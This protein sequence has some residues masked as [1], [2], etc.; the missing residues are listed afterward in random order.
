MLLKSGKEEAQ[1]TIV[2]MLSEAFNSQTDTLERLAHLESSLAS[3]ERLNKALLAEYEKVTKERSQ[4]EDEIYSKM[5]LLLNTKKER[6]RQLES[7]FV[8]DIEAEEVNSNHN[9]NDNGFETE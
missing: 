3:Q 8:E 2:S 4:W 7:E 1:S 9:D 5:R 6:I